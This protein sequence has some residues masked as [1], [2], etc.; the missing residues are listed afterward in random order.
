MIGNKTKRGLILAA[1]AAF[2]GALACGARVFVV[3]AD[4]NAASVGGTEYATAE[5]ALSA[6]T[7][8]TTLKLLSDVTTPTQRLC[9]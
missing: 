5:E 3:R 7:E 8:G 1:A 2:A 4:G 6:W 9:P